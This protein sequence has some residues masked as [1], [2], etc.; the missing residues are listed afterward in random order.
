[1]GGWGG[2]VGGGGGGG[3]G[4]LGGGGCQLTSKSRDQK[5]T[6][7]VGNLCGKSSSGKGN[8]SAANCS[9][10]SYFGNKI[11][12][13]WKSAAWGVQTKKKNWQRPNRVDG[14][15]GKACRTEEIVDRA[16]GRKENKVRGVWALEPAGICWQSKGPYLHAKMCLKTRKGRGGGKGVRQEKEG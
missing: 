11:G 3:G 9:M 1:M 16:R 2:G 14:K 10:F 6:A 5:V 12:L 8:K 15:T 4:C 13:W 7:S